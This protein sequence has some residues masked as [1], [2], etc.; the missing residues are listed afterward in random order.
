MCLSMGNCSYL[1][2]GNPANELLAG[3][4]WGP[5]KYFGSG[6]GAKI[7]R[8]LSRVFGVVGG[9]EAGA[10]EEADAGEAVGVGRDAMAGIGIVAAVVAGVAEDDLVDAVGVHA[11]DEILG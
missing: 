9:A 11:V 10:D 5:L 2:L 8:N 3:I 1:A 6:S 7:S 4:L